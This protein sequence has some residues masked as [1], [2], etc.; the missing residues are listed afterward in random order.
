MQNFVE[1]F[2]S[3]DL[4]ISLWNS[5]VYTL[6][7][8]PGGLILSLLVA[9]GVNNIRG[10]TFYRL[11][12]FMPDVCRHAE[13]RR[14]VSVARSRHLPVE[15]AGVYPDR[16]ARRPDPIL[17]RSDGRQQ[18]PWQNVLPTLLFHA[19]RLSACRT[20]SSS[21]SRPISASPCGTRWCIP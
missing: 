18:Y 15:L 17:A 12:Y 9:M 21:F 14:A 3:P 5:L 1:Q 2:Q 6:I 11:F 16:R 8:V 19:G 13:L 7:A 10:K 4:G 20:S